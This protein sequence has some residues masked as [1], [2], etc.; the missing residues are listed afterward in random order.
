MLHRAL[1]KGEEKDSSECVCVQMC[2]CVSTY[3]VACFCV[4]L[5]VM[6]QCHGNRQ[7][8]TVTWHTEVVGSVCTC[9]SAGGESE[10][11]LTPPPFFKELFRVNNTEKKSDKN[12]LMWHFFPVDFNILA[13]C[14]CKRDVTWNSNHLKTNNTSGNVKQTLHQMKSKHKP[15]SWWHWGRF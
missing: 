7:D 5:I 4:W 10:D 15:A 1:T 14:N 9:V 13:K 12:V 3:M 6:C 11:A 2:L 8:V